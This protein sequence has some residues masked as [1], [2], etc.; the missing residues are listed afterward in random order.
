MHPAEAV[1]SDTE[2]NRLEL[3][4]QSLLK[5]QYYKDLYETTK[6]WAV[7][8]NYHQCG[9]I[10]ILTLTIDNTECRSFHTPLLYPMLTL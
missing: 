1:T 9:T 4:L 3:I 10:P 5:I 6:L 2:S 7:Q 8:A